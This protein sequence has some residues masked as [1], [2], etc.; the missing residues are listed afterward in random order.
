VDGIKATD[1]MDYAIYRNQQGRRDQAILL[2]RH[3]VA[4]EPDMAEAHVQLGWMLQ[5]QGNLNEAISS[6]RQAIQLNPRI[7]RYH[8]DVG[9]VLQRQ[10]Q[11]DEA[12]AEYEK[13]LQLDPNF[14]PAQGNRANVKA[15]LALV[16]RLEAFLRGKAMPANAKE[17]V[18][19]AWLGTLRGWYATS[20]RLYENGFIA[21]SS[22]A[23]DLAAR[24]RYLAAICAA[25]VA[26]GE[27]KEAKPPSED[28]CS[29]LRRQALIW[30]RA[31][32]AAR[33]RLLESGKAQDRMEV[34]ETLQHWR[35]EPGL[36]SLR[37]D[38]ALAKLP[39]DEQAACKHL[40]A[41]VAAVLKQATS[42]GQP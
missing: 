11:L 38:A 32:L 6:L 35:R 24:H 21:D 18:Q 39:P 41:D 30:L 36:A 10:G 16:L 31:D 29:R 15:Q 2:L 40:W 23:E 8:N 19:L 25:R 17:S 34:E 26:R 42:S 27:G 33:A 9:Y 20:L 3:A 4:L 22:T 14:N 28:E 1:L 12:L 37:D 7:G 13:A 5:L